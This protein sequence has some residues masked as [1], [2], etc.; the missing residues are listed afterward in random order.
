MFRT[1]V[2]ALLAASASGLIRRSEFSAGS[3]AGR[4]LLKNAQVVEKPSRHLNEEEEDDDSWI[5]DMSLKFEGCF[6]TVRLAEDGGEDGSPI[7]NNGV[8]TFKLCSRGCGTC[9]GGVY[10][11]NMLEFVDAYTEASMEEMEYQCE[12]ARENC[13]CEDANDDD[14]C[15]QQCWYNLGMMDCIQMNNDNDD[16]EE[17]FEVQR[18]LECAEMENNNNNNNNGNGNGNYA[19]GEYNGYQVYNNWDG[20]YRV[21]P[22]C[23]AD[24]KSIYLGVFY[25]E[26]CTMS[27]GDGAY[28]TMNYGQLPYSANSQEGP[29]IPLDTCVDCYDKEE[30]DNQQEEYAQYQY[31]QAQNQN[32]G[33]GDDNDEGFEWNNMEPLE[34][35]TNA[36]EA[37]AKCTDDNQSGCKFINN[38]LGLLN[39]ASGYTHYVGAP[40][41]KPATLFAWVFGITTVAFGGYAFYL[42]RKIQRG[43]VEITD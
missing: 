26:D 3:R 1:A 7:Q 23:A 38:Y 30:W 16:A 4:K 25:D 22:Y 43:E 15:E 13:D 19:N 14:Q 24:G 31:E 5:A 9:N 17:V 21:G 32:N 20:E 29:L 39:K 2:L 34:F 41:G 33:E 28:A 36:Y 10:A 42:Y 11:T 37:S 27:A 18:Y 12:K 35:C 8:I 6:N 40:G